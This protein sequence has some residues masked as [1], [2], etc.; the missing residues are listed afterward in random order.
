MTGAL[1]VVWF[2]GRRRTPRR[3]PDNDPGV[4]LAKP[5]ERVEAEQAVRESLARQSAV[6]SQRGMVSRVVHSLAQ[7]R[8]ENH[9]ADK[10]RTAML[11]EDQ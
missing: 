11:G 10:V 3:D 4:S 2:L 5:V 9:F 7:I 8:E 1:T 6:R